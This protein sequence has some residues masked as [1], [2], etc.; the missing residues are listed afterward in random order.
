MSSRAP[1]AARLDMPES[2][3]LAYAIFAHCFTCS[4]D[5]FAASRISEALASQGIAVLRFDFTGLGASG[6]DFANTNFSSN[7]ED[8]KLA[9]AYLREHYEAPQILIGH[10]LGGA[11]VL[12]VAGDIPEARAVA[13]IN[14][15]ADAGHVVHSFGMSVADI[16]RDGEAE[17]TLAGRKFNIR[18]DFLDDVRGQKLADKISTMR[19]ALL[20]FHAPGDT[21][22]GIANAAE[23]FT[24]AKHPKSFISLDGADHLLTRRADALYVASVLGSWAARYLDLKPQPEAQIETVP[25]G[26]T[27]RETGKGKFQQQVLS[28]R[29]VLSADEPVDVGGLDSAPSPYDF[30]AIALGACTSMTLRIYASL[31]GIELGKISVNVTHGKVHAQ[32]CAECEGREGRI[33]RFERRI[34]IEGGC[35]PELEA[36]IVEIAGKCPVHRT[37]EGSSVV[38]TRVVA[39]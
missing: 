13:T 20:V 24:A 11:A 2:A 9:A 14:A 7:V 38:A 5:V 6:G 30:L 19:R 31:K 17:V 39:G 3:P 37:L 28:G 1:L 4:K 36:K 27:V 35:P 8:L 18:K 29:H 26:V 34:S 25:D 23:I 15:P 16:E 33:D 10:S 32:D 12:A 22:V 21:I